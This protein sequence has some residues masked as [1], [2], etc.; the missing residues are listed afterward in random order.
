[1]YGA[2]KEKV[3]DVGILKNH[4]F[5]N[6]Q[7]PYSRVYI[8]KAV[9]VEDYFKTRADHKHCAKRTNLRKFLQGIRRQIAVHPDTVTQ[10][11][12]SVLRQMFENKRIV[13]DEHVK[14]A[15]G[16]AEILLKSDL[17]ANE[18]ELWSPSGNRKAKKRGDTKE[19]KEK[20]KMYFAADLEAFTAGAHKACMAG[21]AAL[22]ADLKVEDVQVYTT[23][24]NIM[25][26]FDFVA[27]R[28]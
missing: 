3:F 27:E 26:M 9:E 25:R 8:E 1:V 10:S 17:V 7:L 24:D 15:T 16:L 5:P 22:S 2:D 13:Y 28:L 14:P 11:T 19:D 23:T 4:I 18:Q 6:I 12:M 20:V 21:V